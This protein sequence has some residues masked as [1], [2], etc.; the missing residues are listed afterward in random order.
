MYRKGRLNEI[1]TNLNR[2]GCTVEK[3]C[4]PHRKIIKPPRH[5][6]HYFENCILGSSLV[7]GI[8][9]ENTITISCPGGC[10][11]TM[12][13]PAISNELKSRNVKNVLIMACTNNLFNKQNRQLMGPVET[14]DELYYLAQKLLFEGLNVGIMELIPRRGHEN[15]INRTNR[16]YRD[17]ARELDVPFFI[18]KK[19][20]L[21]HLCRDG[22]H[23]N[24][25]DVR[26]L[27]SDFRRALPQLKHYRGTRRRR[28]TR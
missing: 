4:K 15:I 16:C 1:M 2:R 9:V 11:S 8:F 21:K 19:F 12:C 22:L 6:G 20:K 25:G 10:I 26:E 3:Y 27:A 24:S 23:P 13:A 18:N 17:V 7:F 28:G 5:R 14:S